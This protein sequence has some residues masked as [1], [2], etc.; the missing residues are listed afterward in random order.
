MMRIPGVL[1]VMVWASILATIGIFFFGGY[2]AGKTATEWEVEEPKVYTDQEIMIA[3][4]AGY[5]MYAVGGLLVLLFLFMRKRIQLAMGCVKEASKAMLQMPLIIFFPVCTCN[6]SLVRVGKPLCVFQ[7]LSSYCF[8]F[9]L[10]SAFQVLQGLG[11]LAFMACWTVYAVNIAS[12]GEFSTETYAAAT[13]QIS[14]SN[15]R[16]FGIVEIYPQHDVPHLTLTKFI[17]SR[18][19][20]LNFLTLLRNAAGTCYS[21]F[22][23]AVNSSSLW[24]KLSSQW[25]VRVFEFTFKLDARSHFYLYS[26]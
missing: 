11:F 5:G 25:Q 15:F 19:D 22:F 4:Y 13:V 24:V 6:T 10:R 9:S 21:A 1:P 16:L 8:M 17:Y 12:M 2:Y 3:T 20:R 26:C 7:P 18:S 14:V 23:G